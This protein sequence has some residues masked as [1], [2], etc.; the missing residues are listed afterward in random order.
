MEPTAGQ[1]M[2]FEQYLAHQAERQTNALEAIR[3]YVFY[4]LLIVVIGLIA[5]LLVGLSSGM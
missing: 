5:G 4:L 1:Q 2:S 3:N